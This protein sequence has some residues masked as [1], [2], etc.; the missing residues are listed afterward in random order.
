V[1]SG[2]N[3][4]LVILLPALVVAAMA[5]LASVYSLYALKQQYDLGYASQKHDISQLLEATRISQEMLALQSRITGILNQAKLGSL[6]ESAIY[7][8]HSR[9]VDALAGLTGRVDTLAQHL[10]QQG[11]AGAGSALQREY[12]IYRNL[13]MMATDI[14]AVEPALA[15]GYIDQAKNHYIAFSDQAL[16]LGVSLGEDVGNTGEKSSRAFVATVDRNLLVIGTGLL[17]MLLLAA[18]ASKTVA[19]KIAAIADALNDLA[20]HQENPPELPGLQRLHDAQSGVLKALAASVLSFRAALVDRLR[21]QEQLHLAASVFKHAREGILITK[22][23]GSIIDVNQA[24]I[25]ISG[26]ERDEVIGRNPR[27]LS[28]G[29]HDKTFYTKMWHALKEQ[30][31]WSGEIWNRRKNGEFYAELLTISAIYDL[32][33]EIRH[34]IALFYDITEIKNHQHEL[35]HIAHHDPLTG[36]PNRSLL[37]DRLQH[38]LSQSHR[39][40]EQLIVCYIDLDG[41]KTIND[42]HG[43]DIGDRLL[44]RVA[45][46][47]KRA[48]REGDTLARLG[49]DEFVAVILDVNDMTAAQPLLERLLE[50]AAEEIEHQG[51]TLHCSASMG[52]TLYP[53]NEDIDA[54]QLL[55]QADQAMY[56][57][58]LAGKN[59]FHFFDAEH[60]RSVR[61]HH[62]SVEH[63]HDALTGQEFV[64]YY[65]PKANL[66]SGQVIGAE[67]LIRW[68]HPER[69]ILPPGLFL[70]VIENHPLTVELGDWVLDTAFAQVAAWRKHG[71]TLPV[72]VNI[73]AMHLQSPHFIERL[74]ARLAA[75]PDVPPAAL[76]LEVLETSA[77][78][79]LGEVS[80]IIQQC[81]ALGLGFAID[82]FG[83]GYSS[84]TYL[85]RLPAPVLKIDQSFVRDML[86]DPDDLAI[87]EGVLG[88]ARAFGRKAIAEGVETIAHGNMLL[89]MGCDLA[90]G[91]AIARP[92]PA[93][94]IP[95]WIENWRPD[96]S[97]LNR[98]PKTGDEHRALFAGVSLRA[99]VAALQ[100]HLMEHRDM[101]PAT[102]GQQGFGRW[103]EEEGRQRYGRHPGFRN[104]MSANAALHAEAEHLLHLKRTGNTAQMLTDLHRI[105]TLR[106]DLLDRLDLITTPEASPQTRH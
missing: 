45:D 54:D 34:Y 96:L 51:L 10:R 106:D 36:L 99:W 18:L 23:D 76:E 52:V 30:G 71:L 32:N 82:D 91:Y 8:M 41:F 48:L 39:R 38:A 33:G 31:F 65:Q 105:E 59:R 77:L 5:M 42:R 90:Q 60:D 11:R 86:D 75:Y 61:G 20:S 58:K 24:F 87:L 14:A 25:D 3:Y 69:G 62:E 79:D 1:K 56:Q 55:R 95:A 46:S 89:D 29:R 7:R 2:R 92:M 73:A 49:G 9:E 27:I 72:S 101:P 37:A 50:A 88:L 64:L 67:A 103:L 93:S 22:P 81:L 43:H 26:Y 100:A 78:Q 74:R 80:Q 66:R 98:L 47:M 44:M 28:S 104:V 84:L 83:T 4:L 21:A 19:G 97:W 12:G 68:N 94:E 85:K 70:P 15:A 40:A 6:D 53:Q 102:T 63:I 35:E 13:V 16:K 57:A 17:A